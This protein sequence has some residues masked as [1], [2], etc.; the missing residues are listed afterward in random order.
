MDEDVLLVALDLKEDCWVRLVSWLWLDCWLGGG[1]DGSLGGWLPVM[2]AL[3]A[4]LPLIGVWLAALA[5]GGRVAPVTEYLLAAG[6][7]DAPGG[8]LPAPLVPAEGCD[9][10]IWVFRKAALAVLGLGEM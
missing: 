1:L 8:G 9:W 2:L 3:G 7:I 10:W 6:G 5:A 4:K